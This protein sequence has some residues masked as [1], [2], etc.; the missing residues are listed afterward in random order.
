M[1]DNVTNAELA[2]NTFAYFMP[3]AELFVVANLADFRSVAFDATAARTLQTF[4]NQQLARTDEPHE[5]DNL[6]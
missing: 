5:E 2:A 1:P 4:I 6:C 3:T